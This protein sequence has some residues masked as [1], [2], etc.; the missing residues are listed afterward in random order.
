[1]KMRAFALLLLIVASPT[2]A[3][4]LWVTGKVE[5]TIITED[6]KFGG[7]LITLSTPYN[8]QIGCGNSFLSVDCAGVFGTKSEGSRR[9]D[10]LMLAAVTGA[11]ARVQ[12]NSDKVI[13]GWCAIDG[14][15]VFFDPVGG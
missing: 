9:M 3:A 5:K 11:D 14:V 1:M 7:C 12:I 6:D 13:N 8:G 4:K 15:Q 10:Q 2:F